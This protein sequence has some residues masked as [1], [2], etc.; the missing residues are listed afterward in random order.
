M[1][2]GNYSEPSSVSG[3]L[4]LH[5][6]TLL[7]SGGRQHQS[8]CPVQTQASGQ[9]AVMPDRVEALLHQWLTR[10]QLFASKC[11]AVL[12]AFF[13]VDCHNILPQAFNALHQAWDSQWGFTFPPEHLILQILPKLDATSATV[14]LITHYIV[15]RCHVAGRSESPASLPPVELLTPA[16][17]QQSTK[18]LSELKFMAWT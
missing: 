10:N 15:A 8:R 18:E 1:T 7:P 16:L 17:H 11:N 3:L 2:D 9:M 12:L 5:N 13:L 6:F 4:E 14:L